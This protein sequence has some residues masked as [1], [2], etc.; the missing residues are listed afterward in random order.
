MTIINPNS[1][2]GISSITAQGSGFTVYNSSGTIFAT[3]DS[4]GITASN[5]NGGF[6]LTN[7]IFSGISTFKNGPAFISYT[8]TASSTGTSNQP[9]QV[10]GGAY[11]SGSV[12]VGTTNP[13]SPL[14]VTGNT[15]VSGSIGVGTANPKESLHVIGNINASGIATGNIIA[16]VA[17]MAGLTTTGITTST[18]SAITLSGTNITINNGDLVIGS[19]I[20]P[21]TTVSSG[22]GTT[23]IVLSSAVNSTTSSNQLTIYPS[24]KIVTSNVIAGQLCRAWVNFNGTTASPSTIRA[25]YNVSSVTKNGTGDYTLNFTT[26]MVDVNYITQF[27]SDAAGSFGGIANINTGKTA[28]SAPTTSAV[29]VFVVN[30]SGSVVDATY[31]HV[32]IFR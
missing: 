28:S 23:N 17:Q 29:R 4:T 11:V 27:T 13:T 1:I 12:G 31:C 24:G 30:D 14:H 2:S 7:S 26:A 9:L 8:G 32:A 6:S 25:S 10:N 20:A 5:F 15:Y 22:A 19:G 3:L 16:T 21:G 18:V